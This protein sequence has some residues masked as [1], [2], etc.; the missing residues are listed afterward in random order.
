MPG[1]YSIGLDSAIQFN[2]DMAKRMMYHAAA[3][4]RIMIYQTMGRDMD[5]I[6]VGLA[7]RTGYPL[8]LKM[9][10]LKKYPAQD[11]LGK[12]L[13]ISE[14]LDKD[15][16]VK[17]ISDQGVDC[18]AQPGGYLQRDPDAT[19]YD[20][21]MAQAMA[22]AV[23]QAYLKGICG[24]LVCYDEGQMVLRPFSEVHY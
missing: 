13:I 14:N 12:V 21:E 4:D 16:V 15:K 5:D 11:Y 18:R 8:I 23:M 2:V 10:D 24:V 9:E 7:K 19:Q 1:T 20:L 6:A 22:T 17:F 3:M